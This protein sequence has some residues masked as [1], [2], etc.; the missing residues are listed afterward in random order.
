MI[1][2]VETQINDPP[3]KK[4]KRL[5]LQALFEGTRRAFGVVFGVHL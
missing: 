4:K 1:G 5:G 2:L 3:P